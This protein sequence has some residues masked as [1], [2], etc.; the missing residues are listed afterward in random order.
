MMTVV[1][2]LGLMKN[3]GTI[4]KKQMGVV[5]LKQCEYCGLEWDASQDAESCPMAELEAELW[6]NDIELEQ[7]S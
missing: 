4:P 7:E 2:S 1:L 5:C 3:A 6:P